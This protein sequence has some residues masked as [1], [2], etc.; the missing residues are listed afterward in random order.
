[1]LTIPIFEHD[2]D[3]FEHRRSVWI[4]VDQQQGPHLGVKEPTVLNP[5]ISKSKPKVDILYYSLSQNMSD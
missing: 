1:M 5:H 4:V 3:I 2:P